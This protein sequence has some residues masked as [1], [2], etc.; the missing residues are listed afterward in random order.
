[1]RSYPTRL[2]DSFTRTVLLS[3]C[4]LICLACATPF[5][6]ESLEEGMTTEMVRERFGEPKSTRNRPGLF[7]DSC[8]SYVHEEQN[9]IFTFHPMTPLLTVIFRFIPPHL[10]GGDTGGGSRTRW[11]YIY[12]RWTPVNLHFD[13]EKLVHWKLIGTVWEGSPAV[14]TDW[15]PPTRWEG[16]Y[17]EV[18]FSRLACK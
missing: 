3:P 4:L 10:V 2:G 16:G 6:I 15:G 18:P 17:N 1:M 7:G 12:V 9:W 13:G 8:W 11:D 5:P 14:V